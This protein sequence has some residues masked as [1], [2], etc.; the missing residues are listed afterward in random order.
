MK[1]AV[2]VTGT[3][4]TD[5]G[6]GGLDT[7]Q[8]L[9]A[10]VDRFGLWFWLDVALT[11]AIKWLG[12]GAAGT[13]GRTDLVLTRAG[14]AGIITALAVGAGTDGVPSAG[15]GAGALGP[16]IAIG[17]LPA[18]ALQIGGETAIL[19]AKLTAVGT[20]GTG[21]GA[22]SAGATTAGPG[23]V[24]FAPGAISTTARG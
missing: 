17:R 19:T 15:G 18:T 9:T 4:G 21:A 2:G 6:I 20:A 7:F 13:L 23:T 5:A 12:V 3:F 16:A 22:G 24:G 14:A 8:A 10:G 11:Q 1:G